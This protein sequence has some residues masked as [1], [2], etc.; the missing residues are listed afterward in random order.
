[1]RVCG[2]GCGASLEGRR[3]DA[4][5]LDHAHRERV[6]RRRGGATGQVG[7][8]R[9]TP[10][11]V[12]DGCWVW[13]LAKNV[14]GYGLVARGGRTRIAHRWYYEQEHGPVPEGYEL[15]HVCG[16]RDCV[17]PAHVRAVTRL[18]HVRIHEAW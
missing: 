5:Y 12:R 6:K 10:Y 7:R 4:V 11:E 1:M 16:R 17:N 18:E 9:R 8:R 2:C 15:H 13:L 3:S 14:G